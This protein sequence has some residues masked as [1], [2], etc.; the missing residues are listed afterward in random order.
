MAY[1]HRDPEGGSHS[2]LPYQGTVVHYNGGKISNTALKV[3]MTTTNTIAVKI[4]WVITLS[5][6]S[7]ITAGRYG[8]KLRYLHTKVTLNQVYAA[9]WLNERRECAGCSG[10]GKKMSAIAG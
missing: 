2:R 8:K 6:C 7:K 3:K 5:I 1:L 4:W 10:S 9:G